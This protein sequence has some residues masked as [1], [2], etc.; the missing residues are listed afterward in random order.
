MA[1]LGDLDGDGRSTVAL[2]VGADAD[3]DG[4][5][6]HGAIYIVF[7]CGFGDPCVV[8]VDPASVPPPAMH[9]MSR[10]NPFGVS[11]TLRYTLLEAGQPRLDIYDTG[12]HRVATVASE[13]QSA[14]SR[15][16]TWD[17]RNG[18]G[19]PVVAGVY[20]ARLTTGTATISCKIVRS[21]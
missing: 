6:D 20:F 19:E 16:L 2:A 9:L 12:G 7:L 5:E 14:G 15:F 17:G 4:G 21:R 1:S 10:P 3:D 13:K 8:A 18:T 11:T